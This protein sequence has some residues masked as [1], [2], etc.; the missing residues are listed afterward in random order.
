M[1]LEAAGMIKEVE[2][3]RMKGK[4]ITFYKTVEENAFV[5]IK[6]EDLRVELNFS[7][8]KPDLQVA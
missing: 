7:E 4:K 2:G 6:I 8:K 1:E 3:E 5:D